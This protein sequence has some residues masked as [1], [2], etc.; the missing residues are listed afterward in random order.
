MR[1]RAD[2]LQAQEYAWREI[3]RPGTWWTG[4]ERVAIAAEARH[5]VSCP[6]C[7]ARRDA[8]SPSMVGGDHASLG[9]L[10]GASVEAIHRIR[11]DSGRIGEAWYRGLLGAG[12]DEERYVELISVVVIVVAVDTFRFAIGL[13]PLAL[14]EIHQGEPTRR[15]PAGAKRGL[16]WVGTLA[17]EDVGP[18]DPDLYHVR[19]DVLKRSGANIQRA[20]SLV[21]QSMIQWWDMFE[22]MYMPGPW[23]RDF[24]REYRAVTHAQMEML[25]A[26]VSALNRCEY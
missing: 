20:L 19:P 16:T 14:P 15:R 8:L 6:L 23:M 11:T 9:R 18:D 25:A 2:T 3:G 12:M 5:A 24:S 1:A 4:A 7:A 10:P 22:T 26:R 21:P 17:P 13:D